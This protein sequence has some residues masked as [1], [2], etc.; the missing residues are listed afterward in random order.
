MSRNIERRDDNRHKKIDR[1]AWLKGIGVAGAAALA[2]CSSG[3]DGEDTPG[4]NDTQTDST[5]TSDPLGTTQGTSTDDGSEL[6]EVGGTYTTAIGNSLGTLNPLYNTESTAGGVIGYALDGSYGFKPGSEYFPRIF[7]LSSEDNKT[8]T[9][10]IPEGLTFSDPYGEVTAEDFVYQINEVQKSEWAGTADAASWTEEMTIEEKS[11]YEFTIEL[12]QVNP[13]YPASYDPYIYPVPKALMEP[14]VEEEDVE[15][16]QQ[17]EELLNL[18]FTGNLGAYKLEEWDKNAKITFTRNEDYYLRNVDG[19]DRRFSNAPYF[20][21]LEVRVVPEQSSRL[22]ALKNGEIDTAGLPKNRVNEFK[23]NDGTYVNV[24]PQPYNRVMAYNHRDNGWTTGP[25]NLFRNKKFRQGIGC[26]ID[27]QAI[28]DGIYNGYAKP[29]YTW[30]P[31]WSKWYPD[32]ADIKQ[33]GSGDLY[34]KEATQSR[35]E[36]AISDTDYSYDGDQLVNPDGNQVEL[37]LYYTTTSSTNKS[38]AQFV[39][40]EFAKNAGI[41]VKLEQIQGTTFRDKYWVQE[42]PE[43]PDEYEWSNGGYNAGPYEVTSSESWDMSI[44]YGLNTYPLNPTTADVFF[45]KDSYYN[46]YGYQPEWNAKELFNQASTAE[47]EEDVQEALTEIF[48]N[49]ADSQPMGMLV[50]A[51][52]TIGYR[53]GIEGP[54]ENFFNGWN[55]STWYRNE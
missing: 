50:F 37:S 30:Q 40:Q 29:H 55:F 1:R 49:V 53:T 10:T 47:T 18:S 34:G 19:I 4:G 33:F 22:G 39:K 38:I 51:D 2:G 14:Y 35:I 25:G 54:E 11:K 42:T 45:M 32:N 8:W 27:K 6:P 20:E 17:D 44:V 36:E 24:V 5:D 13:L 12:P 52:D 23:N 41:N 3:G 26:A 7:D 9:A 21:N 31:E 16:F 15:G 43:N 48:V 46:P 28:A